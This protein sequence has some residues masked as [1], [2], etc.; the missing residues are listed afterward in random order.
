MPFFICVL[1][2]TAVRLQLSDQQLTSAFLLHFHLAKS[3]FLLL[4]R[5]I[6]HGF[7]Q[8]VHRNMSLDADL[9]FVVI[10][11]KWEHKSDLWSMTFLLQ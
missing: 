4:N 8:Q 7:L 6:D 11:H 5:I 9:L 2:N 10:T 1:T 3:Y